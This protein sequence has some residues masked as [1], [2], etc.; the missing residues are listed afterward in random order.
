[1]FQYS[2]FLQLPQTGA[3][4][5]QVSVAEFHGDEQLVVLGNELRS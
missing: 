2:N 1:V 3:I 5:S 4:D